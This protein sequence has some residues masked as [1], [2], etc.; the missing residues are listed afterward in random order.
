VSQS[1]TIIQSAQKVGA[2]VAVASTPTSFVESGIQMASL[3]IGAL[4]LCVAAWSA[5]INYQRF[6][7]MKEQD[8]KNDKP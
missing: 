2:T 3:T 8:R 7:Y 1:N 4:G 5:W 6:K